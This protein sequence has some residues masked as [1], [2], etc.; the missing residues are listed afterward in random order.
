MKRA[1]WKLPYIH[2][3]LLNKSYYKQKCDWSKFRNSSIPNNFINSHIR[4][5][6]GAWFLTKTIDELMIGKKI[7][8]FSITK[9]FDCQ[10]QRKKKTKRKTNKQRLNK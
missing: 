9:K 7:G 3:N 4:V 10:I 6:N 2:L 8:E 1:I 5:Y